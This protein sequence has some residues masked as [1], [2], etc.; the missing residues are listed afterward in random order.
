MN[1]LL[2]FVVL[3]IT[4]AS[5]ILQ[6][7]K[8]LKS[9]TSIGI[10]LQAYLITFIAISILTFNADSNY[11]FYLGAIEMVLSGFGVF[12]I[13]YY[14]EDLEKITKSFLIALFGSFFMIHGVMQGIKSFNHRAYS[15]VSVSSYLLWVFMDGIIIYFAEDNKIIIAL[16][17]SVLIYFYIIIDTLYKNRKYKKIYL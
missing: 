12:L 16:F 4:G 6:F 9:K 2:F 14:R 15:N 17:I 10:S 11:V 1:E 3:L 13:Y 7:Y 8:I 5:Y